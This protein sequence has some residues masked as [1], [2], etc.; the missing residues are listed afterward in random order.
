MLPFNL[1]ILH[2]HSLRKGRNV[3]SV[4]G[5]SIIRFFCSCNGCFLT[6]IGIFQFLFLC[7]SCSIS[8]CL[9][10]VLFGRS[11]FCIGIGDGGHISGHGLNQISVFIQ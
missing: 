6:V 9:C 8:I 10:L 2:I 5:I 4:T 11:E 7:S 3:G 1:F